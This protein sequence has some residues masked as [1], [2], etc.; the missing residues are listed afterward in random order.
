MKRYL[1]VLAISCRLWSQTGGQPTPLSITR[2]YSITSS[3]FVIDNRN[4]ATRSN[5]FHSF[6]AT[7]SGSWSVVM[8]HATASAGPWTS[9]SEDSATVT[10]SSATCQGSA[11]GYYPFIRF[12]PTGTVSVTYA[13]AKDFYVVA[14]AGGVS[15]T[16]ASQNVTQTGTLSGMTATTAR[17][18]F[19]RYIDAKDF[20]CA[21]DNVTNDSACIQNAVDAVC[22]LQQSVPGQ[23]GGGEIYFS[24]GYYRIYTT[25]ITIAPTCSN[26]RFRG[27][28][29]MSSIIWY[30]GSTSAIVIGEVGTVVNNNIHFDSL[31][32]YA[33]NAGAN[34]VLIDSHIVFGLSIY[35]CQFQN[36][37]IPSGSNGQIAVRMSGEGLYTIYGIIED[38]YVRGTFKYGYHFTGVQDGGFGQTGSVVIINGAIVYT[39]SP[40]APTGTTG[41]RNDL[42]Y[43][44]TVIGTDIEN[45]DIGV[46]LD[47]SGENMFDNLREEGNTYGLVATANVTHTVFSGG[48]IQ[49][50]TQAFVDGSSGSLALIF[51]GTFF[52][53]PPGNQVLT[54]VNTLK[55]G[56]AANGGTGGLTMDGNVGI[57]WKAPI[58]SGSTGL[59]WFTDTD[60]TI[61]TTGFSDNGSFSTWSIGTAAVQRDGVINIANTANSLAIQNAGVSYLIVD[62]FGVAFPIGIQRGNTSGPGSTTGFNHLFGA[63]PVCTT[64]ATAGDT[65]V[66]TITWPSPFADTNYSPFCSLSD[67]AFSATN[68]PILLDLSAKTTTSIDVRIAT[69][70]NQTATAKVNC[71][72]I[73]Q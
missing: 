13:A 26:L 5:N 9:F 55:V 19:G 42:A 61:V 40:P 72:G 41:I 25:T 47:K 38:S 10:S 63:G 29:Y 66:A 11:F 1:L 23:L 8:Q 44:I 60:Q 52:I 56:A 21:G 48:I 70:I 45:W 6:C 43:N 33:D 59:F 14:N 35:K 22:A 54:Q 16:L 67:D 18:K 28:G 62:T 58:P 65:C 46:Y 71:V 4:Q 36:N 24:P 57:V 50:T 17:A 37:R 31:G 51:L 68:K 32:F 2:Y 73:H 64:G 34:A 53:G 49:G 15:G 7:G 27:S 30:T 39:N 69:L 20:G 3:S 12:N